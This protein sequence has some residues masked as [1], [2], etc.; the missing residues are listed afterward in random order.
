[1]V[2]PRPRSPAKADGE[3]PQ[4]AGA[5]L[6]R[7]LQCAAEAERD[8]SLKDIAARAGLPPSTVHRLLKL[9]VKTD[10]I[11]RAE[12][13]L[14]RIGREFFR[15]AS[16]VMQKFDYGKIARPFL[17]D[18]WRE[19]QETCAFCVYKPAA[20][21]ALVVDTVR[22]EHPLQFVI[23]PL[24]HISLAWGS[25]GRSIL[26][27]LPE[28]DVEVVLSEATRGPLSGRPPPSRAK[29]REELERIR[30]TGFA[31]YADHTYLDVAGVAAPVFGA[32]RAVLGSIG[33]TMP[34]SRFE[35]AD[36]AELCKSVVEK[37]LALS[38]ALGA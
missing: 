38:T 33:V 32:D 22:T 6:V 19:W 7:L 10:M 2:E 4:G 14:Y 35:P 17:E 18:L 26:A 27:H 30:R 12:G 25:L 16:L 21:N 15:L 36:Q 34:A 29:M 8:F 9:L 28:E 5:R 24:S 13:E 23:E 3:D 20:R 31:V 1:M 11:E 37:A